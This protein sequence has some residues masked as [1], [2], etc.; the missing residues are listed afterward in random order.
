MD[1]ALDWLKKHL[2][3]LYEHNPYL[4]LLEMRIKHLEYGKAQLVM[5]IKA[6]KHTNLYGVA[7]GGAVAS[8][9]D[10]VMGVACA[11]YGNRVV[12]IEMNINYIKSGQPGADI[13][14]SSEVIHA[15]R[16]TMVV[17]GEIR[18]QQGI[19]LAKSRGTYCVIGRFD[20]D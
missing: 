17:E 5:P 9:A 2:N 7:H 8:L 19:L 11:T 16:Q 14:G 4:Q 1:Q 20:K 10:T 15:G 3:N 13:I 12:T 18:D 6:S